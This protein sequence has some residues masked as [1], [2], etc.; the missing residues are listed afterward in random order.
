MHSQKP[1]GRRKQDKNSTSEGEGINIPV[2]AILELTLGKL[3]ENDI[4]EYAGSNVIKALK[5][6]KT[7]EGYIML[8]ELTWREGQH[9]L[10]TYRNRPR[11]WASL[12]RMIAYM[13]R[14]QVDLKS[15]VVQMK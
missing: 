10:Y 7:D 4:R 8:V 1:P 15:F 5:V 14:H 3:S 9:T 2:L 11:T 12:D 6:V 13:E